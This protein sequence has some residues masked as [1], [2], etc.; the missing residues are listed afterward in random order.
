MGYVRLS[1]NRVLGAFIR[2]YPLNA[3]ELQWAEGP[4]VDTSQG[5][6]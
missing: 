1:G 6:H 2:E 5:E 3:W 4:R